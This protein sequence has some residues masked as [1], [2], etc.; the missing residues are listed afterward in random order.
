MSRKAVSF[1]SAIS[2]MGEPNVQPALTCHNPDSH[3]SSECEDAR[4]GRRTLNILKL[5]PTQVS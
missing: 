1:T 2:A 4:V 3:K 5:A